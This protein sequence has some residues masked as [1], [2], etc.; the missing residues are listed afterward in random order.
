[1]DIL[2]TFIKQLAQHHRS[3]PLIIEAVYEDH[4]QKETWPSEQELQ[5]LL[6][7]LL[8]SFKKTY[9]VIDALDEVPENTRVDLLT[10]L[11]SL[12][13]SQASLLLTSR[14]LQLLEPFLPDAVYVYIENENRKDIELFINKQMEETPYLTAI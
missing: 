12:R 5:G 13:A 6:Q 2:A 7:Q 9:I 8:N 1:M 14:P 3:M 10:V 4:H 11:S